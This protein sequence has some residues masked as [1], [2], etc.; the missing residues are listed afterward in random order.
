MPKKTDKGNKG[1][2]KKS[3]VQEANVGDVPSAKEMEDEEARLLKAQA[4][5]ARLNKER[6][7]RKNNDSNPDKK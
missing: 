4:K 1:N 2:R 6:E 5:R 3:Y 7:A